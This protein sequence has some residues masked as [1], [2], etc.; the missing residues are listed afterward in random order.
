MGAIQSGITF[1]NEGKPL[2]VKQ[3]KNEN[4]PY[5]IEN[6]PEFKEKQAKIEQT[7]EVHKMIRMKNQLKSKIVKQMSQEEAQLEQSKTVEKAEVASNDESKDHHNSFVDLD[8]KENHAV[9]NGNL[10]IMKNFKVTFGTIVREGRSKMEEGPSYREKIRL[11]S[12]G[13]RTALTLSEY[14]QQKG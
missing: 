11:Q 5:L 6:Q 2:K 1:N 9:E 7:S 13:N 12:D 10:D 14:R 4:L 3:I 8:N